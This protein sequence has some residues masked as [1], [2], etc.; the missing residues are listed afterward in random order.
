[1][2]FKNSNEVDLFIK[3]HKNNYIG[4]GA[5]GECYLDIR[6]NLV[7]KIFNSYFYKED[8]CISP[9]DVLKFSNIT[10]NTFIWPI[11]YISLDNN[12][13]G[14]ITIYKDAISLYKINPLKIN[15]NNFTTTISKVYEDVKIL[16]N[17]NIALNDIRYNMLYSNNNIYIIDTLNYYYS[18]DYKSSYL[19]NLSRI[20]DSIKAFLI[21]GYFDDYILSDNE[22]NDMYNDKYSSG[23]EFITLLKDKL[24]NSLDKKINSLSDAKKLIRRCEGKRN[25]VR[26]Y[27][28]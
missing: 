13:I 21:D 8:S 6:T 28:K 9:L 10:N 27:N 12:V 17:N 1:M 22:L 24:T 14:Y 11:D 2:R 3:K 25:Y 18:Y 23:L 4:S 19:N 7:Y 16:S 15:L 20:D 26:G 5:E